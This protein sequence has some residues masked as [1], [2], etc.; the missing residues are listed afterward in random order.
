MEISSRFLCRFRFLCQLRQLLQR[1]VFH[2]DF[3]VFLIEGTHRGHIFPVAC[4]LGENVADLVEL[5]RCVAGFAD[6]EMVLSGQ[7]VLVEAVFS[8]VMALQNMGGADHGI[9]IPEPVKPCQIK[10]CGV[11]W[12]GF[13]R[14]LL[15]SF[16]GGIFSVVLLHCLFLGIADLV[17][18]TQHII[19]AFQLGSDG[20]AAKGRIAGCWGENL[21]KRVSSSSGS[22]TF[23][24]MSMM[25]SEERG[26][27][28]IIRGISFASKP[29]S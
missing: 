16:L 18:K 10:G 13:G 5:L 6:D 7:R 1:L 28:S 21:A 23:V 8:V 20:G 14:F 4:I 25:E 15:R 9:K 19:G 27:A 11:G 17:E 24:M 2:D 12:S 22:S 3:H 29:N 26:I